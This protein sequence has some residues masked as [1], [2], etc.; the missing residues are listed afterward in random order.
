MH[1]LGPRSRRRPGRE[2]LIQ[3]FGRFLDRCR[4]ACVL[5]ADLAHELAGHGPDRRA[6]F[7]AKASDSPEAICPTDYEPGPRGASFCLSGIGRVAS[8]MFGPGS[9]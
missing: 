3:V 9:R 8:A 7:A 4:Q 6:T 1:I 5:P 2:E